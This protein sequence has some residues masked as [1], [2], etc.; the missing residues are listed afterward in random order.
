MAPKLPIGWPLVDVVG[1]ANE[2]FAVCEVDGTVKVFP[3]WP[4]GSV[5]CC[6]SEAEGTTDSRVELD[7]APAVSNVV[8]DEALERP[9]V[10]LGVTTKQSKLTFFILFWWKT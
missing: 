10:V 5:G 2:E 6:R 3:D 8:E 9:S 7:A 1:G 4:D